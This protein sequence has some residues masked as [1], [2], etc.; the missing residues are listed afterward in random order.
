MSPAPRSLPDGDR[1]VVIVGRSDPGRTDIGRRLARLLQRPF[2]DADEQVE[3]TAG[4][5]RSPLARQQDADDL[6]RREAQVLAHLLARDDPLVILAPGAAEVDPSCVA[7]L[8]RSAVVLWPRGEEVRGWPDRL[9]DHYRDVADHVVDLAPFHAGVEE[10][11][12]AIAHHILQLF[13][14]GELRHS[15]RLPDRVRALA[16]GLRVEDGSEVMSRLEDE[17]PAHIAEIA[18]HVVDVERFQSHDEPERAIAR[19]IARL[20]ARDDPRPGTGG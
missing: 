16:D 2:A 9:A 18:D 5:A 12:R 3:L 1:H 15:V 20:L 8:A 13:V 11:E 14:T 6:R 17:L 10:P 7:L 4:R 19:H